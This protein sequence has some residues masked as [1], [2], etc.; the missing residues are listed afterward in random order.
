[1]L[2]YLKMLAFG[3]GEV[4]SF[5]ILLLFFSKIDD[6]IDTMDVLS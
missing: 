3:L 4:I 5:V 1:M 2:K 6:L